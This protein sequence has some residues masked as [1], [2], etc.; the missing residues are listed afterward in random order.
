YEK[1][2]PSGHNSYW[3]MTTRERTEKKLPAKFSEEIFDA[4][5][6][7]FGQDRGINPGNITIDTSETNHGDSFAPNENDPS[8]ESE[9]PKAACGN[10]S[11][12]K[13]RKTLLKTSD[14][15]DTIVEN[16]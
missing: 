8:N 11:T 10:Q 4:M 3:T 12:R 16:N 1:N 9:T 15:K 6:L 5:E 2:I 14:I 13:K 7:N